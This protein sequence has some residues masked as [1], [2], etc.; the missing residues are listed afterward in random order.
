MYISVINGGRNQEWSNGSLRWHETNILAGLSCELV[1][2]MNS[3]W[4]SFYNSEVSRL[5]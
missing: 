4:R 3:Y 5:M 2:A 1:A